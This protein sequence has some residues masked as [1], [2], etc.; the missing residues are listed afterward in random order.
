MPLYGSVF[1]Q[2]LVNCKQDV[3]S[4]LNNVYKYSVVRQFRDYGFM[5][6]VFDR[7]PDFYATTS[8]KHLIRDCYHVQKKWKNIDWHCLREIEKFHQGKIPLSDLYL[9]MYG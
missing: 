7:F 8:K 3:T 5:L 2:P 9:F 1:S 6:G 4:G